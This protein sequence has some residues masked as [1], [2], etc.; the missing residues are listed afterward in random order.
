MN[1][2]FF[3]CPLLTPLSTILTRLN[4]EVLAQLT[5]G[6][7]GAIAVSWYQGKIHSSGI[8]G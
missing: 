8:L 3:L 6:W 2:Y 4:S 7:L 1:R 5:E